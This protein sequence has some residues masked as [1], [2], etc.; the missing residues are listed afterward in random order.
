MADPTDT[1]A[2]MRAYERWGEP[3]RREDVRKR[4]RAKADQFTM[5]GNVRRTVEVLAGQ[6]VVHP[7]STMAAGAEG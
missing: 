1:L 6:N 5:N 2:L 3:K 7:G 4:L